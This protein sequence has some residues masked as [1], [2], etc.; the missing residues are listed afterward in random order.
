MLLYHEINKT[1]TH[2]FIFL[3][4]FSHKYLRHGNYLDVLRCIV[5]CATLAV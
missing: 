1:N 4:K 5:V 2:S 3:Q